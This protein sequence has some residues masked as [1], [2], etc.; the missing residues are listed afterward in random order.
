MRAIQLVI[1]FLCAT[2]EW[3]VASLVVMGVCTFVVVGQLLAVLCFTIASRMDAE[4]G[5]DE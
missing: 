1:D 3:P 4:E 5:G 2:A